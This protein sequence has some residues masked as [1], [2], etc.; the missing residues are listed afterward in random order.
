MT[1][2]APADV[3]AQGG[4]DPL[5]RRFRHHAGNVSRQ[6][7]VFLAG[8]IFLAAGGYL[9]K[10]YVSRELGA[11]GLGIYSMGMAI[12]G[13][14]GL[15]TALGVPQ[16]TARYVAIDRGRGDGLSIRQFARRAVLF[17]PDQ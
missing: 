14:A 17:A 10:I 16:T 1:E 11:A 12:A 3:A 2:P 4:G 13:F 8:T 15:F 7:T 9:F 6:A 5:A